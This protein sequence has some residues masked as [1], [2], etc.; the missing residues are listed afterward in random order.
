MTTPWLI[1]RILAWWLFIAAAVTGLWSAFIYGR[2]ALRA[3]HDVDV[4][5]P[6][7][8]ETLLPTADELARWP[9]YTIDPRHPSLFK[10]D[11]K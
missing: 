6:E 7:T 9:Y 5:P 11:E 2:D 10:D 1:A 4:T 3:R 8:V